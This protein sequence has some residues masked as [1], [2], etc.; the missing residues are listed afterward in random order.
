MAI[1]FSKIDMIEAEIFI[2]KL[3][4]ETGISHRFLEA[5]RPAI[6]KAFT[7]VPE[8]NRNNCL[9][10]IRESVRRQAETEATIESAYNFAEQIEE[11]QSALFG[12]LKDLETETKRTKNSLI[13]AVLNIYT[14]NPEWA[15][16]DSEN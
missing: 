10:A 14:G 1:D 5:A 3:K 4:A 12:A 2:T 6:E 15:D 16:Y 7:L 8:E 11:K 13:A 9:D